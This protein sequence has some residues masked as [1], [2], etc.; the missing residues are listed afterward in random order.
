MSNEIELSVIVPVKN[1][2]GNV[3]ALVQEIVAAFPSGPYYE[4]IYVDDGSTDDTVDQ[5][6]KLQR[7]YPQLRLVRHF[8]PAGRAPRYAAASRRRAAG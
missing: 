2:A 4:I 8:A 7:Q 1:E 6:R 3:T 5:L